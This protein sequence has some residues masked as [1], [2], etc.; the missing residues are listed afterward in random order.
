MLPGTTKVEIYRDDSGG[1]GWRGPATVLKVNEKAGTAIVEFQGRPYLVGLRHIRALREA[2]YIN[3]NTENQI[4]ASTAAQRAL[5]R[6][7]EVVAEA[8]PHRPSRWARS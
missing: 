8:T 4:D 6:M 3:L 2:F 5:E 7:K 1:Q